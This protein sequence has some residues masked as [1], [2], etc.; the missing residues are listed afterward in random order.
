[1]LKVTGMERYGL[2]AAL[3][4]ALQSN[5]ASGTP[6][7]VLSSAA[8]TYNA[9]IGAVFNGANPAGLTPRGTPA[10]SEQADVGY[11]TPTSG[12]EVMTIDSGETGTS[13]AWGSS[14]ASA[15]CSIILELQTN[16]PRLQG[17]QIQHF[18]A[19]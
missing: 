17:P 6:T 1:M 8:K 11:A 2:A 7:P 13:I 12:L 3:Q 19:Q 9:L 5:Q 16:D 4:S 14:S 18:L 15:F 10:Y